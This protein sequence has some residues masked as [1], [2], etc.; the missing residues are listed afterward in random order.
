MT[1]DD[2][3]R[4]LTH[5]LLKRMCYNSRLALVVLLH[6][7]QLAAVVVCP[8]TVLDHRL[9]SAATHSEVERSFSKLR[10]LLQTLNSHTHTDTQ[11]DRKIVLSP[12]CSYVVQDRK[13]A[14]DNVIR[15]S[16]V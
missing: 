9:I 2:Y 11:A 5:Q 15:I 12:D 13:S 10:C 4:A 3:I 8:V 1:H 14:L 6:R 16:P 7:L